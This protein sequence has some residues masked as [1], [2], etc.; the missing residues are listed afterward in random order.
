DGVCSTAILVRALR[1]RLHVSDP[2]AQVLVRRGMPEPEQARAFLA[3]DET[4]SPRAFAGIAHAVQTIA[5]H[6]DAASPITVHG[7]YDVDGVCST[8][9]LVRALREL[10]ARVDWHLPERAEGYGLS[11]H[12]VR[13]LHA[14]G[15]RL[16][17][18]ADCAI[19]AVAEVALARALGMDV[20]VSDHHTPRADGVLPDAP[21]IHPG[22]CRYPCAE[23]CAAAVAHK[24]TQAL[25]HA[26]GRHPG[27]LDRDLDL[28]AL[29][30]VAD[31]VPLRGENRTLVRRGLPALAASARPGLR[32]LMSVARV[33]PARLDER[34]LGF[35]LA[36]RLNAAGRMGR[37]DTALELL[38]TGDRM[39]AAQIAQE[40]DRANRERREAERR[41][42]F[43][44]EAQLAS[45]GGRELPRALV[46]AGEGWHAGVIGIVASRIAE[47]HHRPTILIALDGQRGR[48][49]GR[50][51]CEA[52]DLLAGLHACAEHLTRYGGHRAAAGLEIERERLPAF[53]QALRRHAARALDP[54]ELIPRERVDALVQGADLHIALAQELRALGPFGHANPTVSLMVEG[55]TFADVRPMGEGRHARF[56][57][58]TPG[59]RARAVAFNSGATL[60]VAE[61]EP[62]LATF[63]LE[64]NEWNGISEPRLVL[65]RA[66]PA[67]EHTGEPLP[68]KPPAE[69]PAE[70]A[71]PQELALFA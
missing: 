58:H 9:I 34:A 14:R 70:R 15:T 29:A 6:L 47:H 7:D 24:L 42:R 37:A 62:A 40:L 35:A 30:T 63:A 59:G 69:Q 5:R 38:L 56:T 46:L 27:E 18:T 67:H 41:I 53:A 32:A 12:T 54:G 2:L 17:I 60:P 22:V 23:L 31:V 39:R 3:A 20:L 57:V 26:R 36:P 16:L 13:R 21:I 25:W 10:G 8:A 44:A 61:G 66:C 4:H 28:V 52:Y 1:E 33:D 55:S 71:A 45:H 48:G 11:E 68:A 64:V 65:R 19:S 50:A 43:Q 51:G 49:S